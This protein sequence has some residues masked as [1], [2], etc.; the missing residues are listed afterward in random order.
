MILLPH[1]W[2]RKLVREPCPFLPVFRTPNCFVFVAGVSN[3][4][5]V[6]TMIGNDHDWQS[7]RVWEFLFRDPFWTHST[8]GLA[9][10]FSSQGWLWVCLIF[11]THFNGRL[12]F[13][14]KALVP[15]VTSWGGVLF[16]YWFTSC[17]AGITFLRNSTWCKVHSS[18][19]ALW[20]KESISVLVAF[21]AVQVVKL[22]FVPDASK[23]CN[24][25]S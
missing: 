24:D 11:H 21:S 1:Y 22:S 12:H 17:S 10:T 13:G 15:M 4:L 14:S 8:T 9:Q 7:P 25:G 5:L 16:T 23:T 3:F 19:Q 2:D 6:L 20:R 18:N